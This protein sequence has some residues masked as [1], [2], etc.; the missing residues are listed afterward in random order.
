[1]INARCFTIDVHSFEI[2]VD[3][4]LESLWQVGVG[5]A[6]AVLLDGLPKLLAGDLSVLQGIAEVGARGGGA[7]KKIGSAN[8][9]KV[10]HLG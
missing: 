6:H 3:E 7:N 2:S 1:M 10:S 4:S 9:L 8:Y 5:L